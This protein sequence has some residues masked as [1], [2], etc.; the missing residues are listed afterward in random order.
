MGWQRRAKVVDAVM[1]PTSWEPWGAFLE[2]CDVHNVQVHFTPNYSRDEYLV[3]SVSVCQ[4]SSSE[5]PRSACPGSW[6]YVDPDSPFRV[7]IA[8]EYEWAQQYEQTR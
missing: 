3:P 8:S 6:L 2:W 1:V 5:I 4:G 7:K